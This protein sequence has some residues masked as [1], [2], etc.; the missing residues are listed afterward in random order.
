LDTL[1]TN[2]LPFHIAHKKC[3][4]LNVDGSI[5]KAVA[6]NAYKFEMFIFDIYERVNEIFVMRVDRYE[7]FAPTKNKEGVDSPETSSKMY[8]DYWSKIRENKI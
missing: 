1:K 2:K 5:E 4:I 3:D 8:E 6:P 7:E